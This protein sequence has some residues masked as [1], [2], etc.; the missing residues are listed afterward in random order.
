MAGRAP[1]LSSNAAPSRSN[2]LGHRHQS[3]A[4]EPGDSRPL[5]AA[6]AY[7]HRLVE[8]EQARDALPCHTTVAFY[9]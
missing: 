3:T 5:P 8:D 4:H 1:P 2:R 9:S 6:Y 7:E